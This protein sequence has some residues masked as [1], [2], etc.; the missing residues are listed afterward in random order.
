MKLSNVA[1]I[2]IGRELGTDANSCFTTEVAG[3]AN[4]KSGHVAIWDCGGKNPATGVEDA[5][6]ALN[7]N[8]SVYV[9]N[10]TGRRAYLCAVMYGVDE[11]HNTISTGVTGTPINVANLRDV[12]LTMPIDVDASYTSA[13]ARI[14]VT[15]TGGTNPG[16][17]WYG[18]PDGDHIHLDEIKVTEFDRTAGPNSDG[19]IRFVAL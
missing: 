2:N 17:L 10:I 15:G 12:E 5:A 14:C 18:T 6:V 13:D 3:D 8:N 11:F 4:C 9:G 19:L 7:V 1:Y 16:K